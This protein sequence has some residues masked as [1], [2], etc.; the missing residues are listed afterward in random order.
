MAQR[1]NAHKVP[2]RRREKSNPVRIELNILFFLADFHTRSQK[3]CVRKKRSG[4]RSKANPDVFGF[5]PIQAF[6]SRCLKRASSSSRSAPQ[7]SSRHGKT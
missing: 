6:R 2:P 7:S 5:A 4:K 3:K 1:A